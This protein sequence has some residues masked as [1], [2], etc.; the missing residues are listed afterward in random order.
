V[1]RKT[2]ERKQRTSV[3]RE[4]D[5]C[6]PEIRR[7]SRRQGTGLELP[8]GEPD[9]EALRSATREWLVPLLVERFLRRQGIELRARSRPNCLSVLDQSVAPQGQLPVARKRNTDPFR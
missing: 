7:P 6:R 2:N 1:T 3:P 4:S 5:E 9:L 8:V